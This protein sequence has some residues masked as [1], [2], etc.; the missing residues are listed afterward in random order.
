MKNSKTKICKII[1]TTDKILQ[2][3]RLKGTTIILW[4]SSYP[5]PIKDVNSLTNKNMQIFRK[6]NWQFKFARILKYIINQHH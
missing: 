2:V 1:Q 5:L 3:Y 4:L 6:I